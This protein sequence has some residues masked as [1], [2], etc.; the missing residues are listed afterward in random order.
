MIRILCATDLLLKSEAALDRA[1]LLADDVEASVSILHVVDPNNSDL[2]LERALHSAMVKMKARSRR[3]L[4]EGAVLPNVIVRAGN[5]ARLIVENL[6]QQ[7]IDLVVMGPH[8]QRGI[9]DT[10]EG[11][12]AARVM[13]ARKCPVLIVREAPRAAYRNVVLAVDLSRVSAGAVRAAER[14]AITPSTEVVVVH[15]SEA[16]YEGMLR[17]GGSSMEAVIAHGDAWT[18][19][20]RLAVRDFLK[21]Q[22]SDSDRYEVVIAERDA[23][24]LIL[25]TVQRVQPDLLVMGTRGY[26]RARRALL[27][28]VANQVMHQAKCDVLVVPEGSTRSNTQQSSPPRPAR[29]TSP[30]RSATI[31]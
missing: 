18:R 26:G 14:L 20:A 15:A 22:S 2:G 19:V 6:E 28:S 1:A 4:W 24:H 31:S 10:L 16:P 7:K 11:T 27:G 30:R 12:I 25:R 13:S 17:Y 21:L 5:P 23:T 9:R 3:P 8:R 29:R